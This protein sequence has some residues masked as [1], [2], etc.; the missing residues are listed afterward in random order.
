LLLDDLECLASP[1]SPQF[2]G[3]QQVFIPNTLPDDWLSSPLYSRRQSKQPSLPMTESDCNA[4]VQPPPSST[5]IVVLG[6]NSSLQNIQATIKHETGMKG[7]ETK[8]LSTKKTSTLN[9]HAPSFVPQRLLTSDKSSCSTTESK[10]VLALSAF[11][12]MYFNQ[13]SHCMVG[14]LELFL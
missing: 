12:Q 10:A 4:V 14:P 7:N 3:C 2:I 1:T 13:A 8:V 11:T 6:D 9:A 5:A